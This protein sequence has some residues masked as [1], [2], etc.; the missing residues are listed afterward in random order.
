MK[1]LANIIQNTITALIYAGAVLMMASAILA[2]GNGLARKLL[3]T[4]FPW[5]EELCIYLVVIGFFLAIPYL[6]LK[7]DQLRIG[8]L[9]SFIKSKFVLKI[10]FI[11]FGCLEIVLFSLLSYYGLHSMGSARLSGV[12]T[13]Y[14]HIPKYLLYGSAIAVFVLSIVSWLSITF[15]NKGESFE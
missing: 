3:N 15:L 5:A 13:N 4:S 8:L 10:L 11:L 1:R 6:E 9:K 12:T 14:L 7:N 2:T